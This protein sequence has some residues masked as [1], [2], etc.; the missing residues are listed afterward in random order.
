MSSRLENN[1]KG[2]TIIELLL[3]CLILAVLASVVIPRYQDIQKRAA[4][5]AEKYLSTII[6]N[7]TLLYKNGLLE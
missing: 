2:L 1:Q 5:N 7:G 3:A 6:K 4:T